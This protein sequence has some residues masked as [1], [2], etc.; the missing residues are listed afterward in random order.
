M[1]IKIVTYDNEVVSTLLG[2]SAASQNDEIEISEQ[3]KLRYDET[4]VQFDENL[5]QIISFTLTIGSSVMSGVVANWL[6]DKLKGRK[7]EKLIIGK[8]EVEIDKGKIKI[9]IEE[10]K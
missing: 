10:F 6:Y 4:T 5:R 1:N 8:K 2:K 7:I 3:I 9:A